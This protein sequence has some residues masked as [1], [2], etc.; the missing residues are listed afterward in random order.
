LAKIVVEGEA[1]RHLL[2]VKG[3]VVGHDWL[4]G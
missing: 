3:D 2:R 4:L 1:P